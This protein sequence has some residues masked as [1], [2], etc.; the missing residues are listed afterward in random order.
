MYI[1]H[2]HCPLIHSSQQTKV[3]MIISYILC[4]YCIPSISLERTHSNPLVA[5]SCLGDSVKFQL[6]QFTRLS[7]NKYL[8]ENRSNGII[9]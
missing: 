3:T 9:V 2:T 5:N 6:P 8:A 1:R 7:I 4:H